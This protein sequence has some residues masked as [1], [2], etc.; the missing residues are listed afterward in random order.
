MEDDDDDPRHKHDDVHSQVGCTGLQR[1]AVQSLVFTEHTH[2]SDLQVG[3]SDTGD[4]GAQ[5]NH[6]VAKAVDV[7]DEDA[8]TGQLEQGGVVAEWVEYDPPAA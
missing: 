1:F 6:R 3:K 8:L 7:I 2:C 5:Q 4:G